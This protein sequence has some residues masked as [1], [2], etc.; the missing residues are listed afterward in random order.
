MVGFPISRNET[1]ADCLTSD[2]IKCYLKSDEISA[3]YLEIWG[4][5]TMNTTT[6]VPVKDYADWSAADL[7]SGEGWKYV[8]KQGEIDALCNM[9]DAIRP[10]LDGDP[11]RLLDMGRDAFDLGAFAPRLRQVYAGLKSGLGIALIRGLPVAEL[12]P[13]NVAIIYW[14]IGRH[15]GDA[16]PNNPEGDMFGHITDLGKTQADPHS[17]GYQT[18]EAMDYHCDQCD[19]VGLLCIRTA[20]EGG[21]SKVASSVAMYNALLRDHPEY[22]QVLTEPFYWTKH[23][24]HAPHEDPYYTSPVFNFLGGRLCTSFG[25]KHIYKGHDLPGTP[26]L[27]A[28]QRAAIEAAE[29]IADRIHYGMWLEPGDIQFVNN[30]V[31]LHTRSAYVDHDHPDQKRLLWRLWL[32]NSDLRDRTDYAKQWE[33][34]V[35][36]GQRFSR[37]RL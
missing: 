23:G 4:D 33:K 2:E 3:R 14:A 5:E 22:A 37:I 13:I 21:M 36:T 26:P 32:M 35:Q 8:L 6:L 9:A 20:R 30:Y 25:P 31:S 15:L 19:L 29:D 12:D 17:R 16:R 18:R 1:I 10:S 28:V 24:E 34:G 27:T 11:D 7:E